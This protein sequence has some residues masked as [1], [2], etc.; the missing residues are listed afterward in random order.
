M[1]KD[2]PL[3]FSHDY[4]SRV[5]AA[6]GTIVAEWIWAPSLLLLALDPLRVFQEGQNTLCPR[7]G[8]AGL[9][10]IPAE[11]GPITRPGCLLS[12]WS[13]TLDYAPQSLLNLC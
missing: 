1:G 3:K 9:C 7:V 5:R 2:A 13:P 8:S 6:G 11:L 4:N 10:V 12:Q